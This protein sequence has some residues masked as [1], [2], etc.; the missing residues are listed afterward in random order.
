M[1]PDNC[2]RK[3]GVVKV[4]DPVKFGALNANNSEMAKDTN[5]KFDRHTPDM[6]AE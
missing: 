2:F 4:R 3:V 1:T 6:S 5:F